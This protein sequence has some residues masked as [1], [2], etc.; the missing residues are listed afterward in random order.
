MKPIKH[1]I[2]LAC[3]A[4][5][6]FASLSAL[7]SG[8]PFG[9]NSP[10]ATARDFPTNTHAASADAAAAA[11]T[12]STPAPADA[13]AADAGSKVPQPPADTE[14]AAAQTTT[15][16]PAPA[17]I[18]VQSATVPAND[19]DT[20]STAEFPADKGLRMNFRGVPLEMVLNYMSKA[21]GYI[22]NVTRS[23]DVKGKVDIWSAQPLS[24]E[25][26]VELLKKVL[27]Q[28]GYTVMQDKRILT[29]ISSSQAKSNEGTPIEK[30]IDF[31]AIPKDT[32]IVTEVIPV[33]SLNPIQLLKDLQDLLPQNTTIVANENANSLIMTD[34]HA[35]IR[36]IAEIVATL[37]SVSSG[38]NTLQVFPLKY[39]DAKTVSDMLKEL[40]PAQDASSRGGGM[41]YGRG[42]YMGS[43]GGFAGSSG[44]GRESG[45]EAGS[46]QAPTTH[47]GAV[48][49]DH[50][51]SVIVSAPDG[52]MALITNV[53]AQIDVS[54]QAVTSLKVFKLKHA[55]P[56]E[57]AE[58]LSNLFPDENSASGAAAQNQAQSGRSY[59]GGLAAMMAASSHGGNNTANEKSNR[60]QLMG[61]VN[62][63]PDPRTGSLVVTAANDLMP[64][65]ESMI[66]DLDENPARIVKPHLVSL[67]NADPYDVL[68]ILN[69]VVPPNP[70]IRSS[71]ANN[72][73]QN[74]ALQSRAN[75][76]SQSQNSSQAAAGQN[77]STTP[78]K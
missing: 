65:I 4:G 31:N 22:I 50:S 47:V 5:G 53:I 37:D 59:F 13:P 26:S 35:N 60:A 19:A 10:T 64:Q 27:N 29:I 32:A 45:G 46:G 3:V 21:A 51:N 75:T 56:V 48:A 70:L 78:G 24:K 55:D 54:V 68:Q 72:S 12:N 57:M 14:S 2:C 63:V 69:D 25:E 6:V 36:R 16:T 77:F 71:S 8:R 42:G 41:R 43:F 38:V 20:N 74:N 18:T 76:I 58:L 17:S 39:A 61:R 34:T 33:R 30:V 67:A 23:V 44:G 11:A 62:A 28:N 40:F 73:T 49:D 66:K 52:L 1:L 9:S 15:P 7:A